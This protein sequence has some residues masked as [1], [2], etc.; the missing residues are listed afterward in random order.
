MKCSKVWRKASFPPVCDQI[1]F[2]A[3]FSSWFCSFNPICTVPLSSFRVTAFPPLWYEHGNDDLFVLYKET[4][5]RQVKHLN[6]LKSVCQLVVVFGCFLSSKLK[7]KSSTVLNA[8]YLFSSTFYPAYVFGYGFS[9]VCI[10]GLISGGVVVIFCKLV[11][12]PSIYSFATSEFGLYFLPPQSIEFPKKSFWREIEVQV[13][14][15]EMPW[16]LRSK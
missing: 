10:Y 8:I 15:K 7:P 11:S 1:G 12:V 9:F 4:W 6:K 13:K 2:S 3:S 14:K 5:F 16:L